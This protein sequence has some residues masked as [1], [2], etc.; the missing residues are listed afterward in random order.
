MSD[1]EPG[2]MSIVSGTNG[3]AIGVNLTGSDDTL[4]LWK[5]RNGILTT[6]I[7]CRVNW[8]TTIGIGAAARLVVERTD[9]GTWNVSVY[10]MNG[11]LVSQATGF[12]NELF[13]TSWFGILYRYSSTRDRL[14]WFDEISIEGIFYRD[15][16]APEITGCRL[17]GRNSIE[18][19][20]SEPP[21]DDL[22][23]PGNFLLSGNGTRPLYVIKTK[24]L[25]YSIGFQDSFKNKSINNLLINK[26]CDNSGNCNNNI[27][28]QFNAIWAE[29]GDVIISEIMADPLPEVSLPGI[30]YLEITNR[31]EYSFNMKNWRLLFEN[32]KLLIPDIII[33]PFEII[34]LCSPANASYFAKFGK[35]AEI[36][37]FPSLTDGGMIICLSDSSGAIIHG[38]EYSQEWYGDKLK[39]AGGWSL[40]MIDICY[41][42]FDEGNWTASVSNKG[43][44]PGSANSV[45]KSNPDNSFCGIVNVFPDDSINI[46]LKFSEPVFTLPGEIKSIKIKGKPVADLKTVDPI[47]KEFVIHPA[48][49]LLRG[50][51]YELEI[52]TEMNDFAGNRIEKFSFPFGLTE[53]SEYGDILFNELLFNPFPADADYIELFNNSKKIIDASRLLLVSKDD[54]SQ[55]LS[56]P[57]PVSEEK[58]CILPEDYYAI[59]TDKDRIADRYFSSSSEHL[60]ETYS[61]PSMNDD[62]GHLIL[63]NREL[64]KIDEVY[65]NYKM[66]FSLLSEYEGVALE[67][68][69]PWNSSNEASNWHSASESSGWG[70]PGAPNSVYI[71]LPVTSD[72]VVFS[73]SRITPDSDGF[74]DILVIK[75]NLSGNGNVVSVMIFDETGTYIRKLASNLYAGPEASIIWDGTAD[76]GTLV[77]SG[78]YIVYIT[79]YDDT[80]K[81]NRWKK[82]CSVIRR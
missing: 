46:N 52:S 44:T 80:G 57:I 7:N 16:V 32:K 24:A 61:L 55:Y 14:I 63:Y 12:D 47:F 34:I 78:I 8:Q 79:L 66:H 62:K 9:A 22:M 35:V 15:A 30:E 5:V 73:S 33:H 69:G 81:T 1:N 68:S 42:F 23:V 11:I 26:I 40:E 60:F 39:S 3:Y 20:L 75:M 70:T 13:L 74:E 6:V 31:T 29:Q 45:F 72:E 17:T 49:P 50:E 65:Y 41:P 21:S 27:S 64:K 58:R 48:E 54:V 2:S 67:K 37:Q 51:I 43:G 10:R 71:E 76:D 36:Y 19:S 25:T 56:Q 18:I 53:H 59:T 82:V 4:R 38:V 28:I 77:Y